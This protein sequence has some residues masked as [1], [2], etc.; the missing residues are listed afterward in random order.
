VSL[1]TAE[2][3]GERS[4]TYTVNFD[5]KDGDKEFTT[6]DAVLFGQFQPGTEWSLVINSMLG[7]VVEVSAP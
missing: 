4:E 6:S 3:E 1:A 5:T 2:R 7:T